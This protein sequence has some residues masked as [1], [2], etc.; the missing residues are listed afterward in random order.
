MTY[1]GNS[2]LIEKELPLKNR[3]KTMAKEDR[4]KTATA[5]AKKDRKERDLRDAGKFYSDKKD[6]EKKRFGKK[7]T[8]TFAADFF[9]DNKNAKNNAESN[10]KANFV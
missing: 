1:S 10:E 8:A 9:P 3:K 2:C 7:N 4:D 6:D 5:S